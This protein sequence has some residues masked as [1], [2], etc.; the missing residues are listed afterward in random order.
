MF[1]GDMF[2]YFTK[3]DFKNHN[4]IRTE[5]MRDIPA[6]RLKLGGYIGP[7]AAFFYAIGF[8]Q[9]SLVVQEQYKILG[10]IISCLFIL[11]IIIGGAYHSH[12]TYVGLLG[13]TDD[14]SIF[15]SVVKNTRFLGILYMIPVS[16]GSAFLSI[17]IVLEKTIFP[18]WFVFFT[19]TIT[20]FFTILWRHLPQPFRVVLYGGWSNL[21]CLIYFSMSIIV[22]C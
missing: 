13:K 8:L 21:L 15:D 2:L 20:I 5:V 7:F 4:S 6:W 16:I 19:P 22:L 11:G 3:K 18:A 1:S 12:Y 14:K 10:F 17:L 9:M